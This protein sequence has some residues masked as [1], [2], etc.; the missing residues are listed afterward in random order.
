MSQSLAKA[1][2][3]ALHRGA[4]RTLEIGGDREL[5]VVAMSGGVDSSMAAA[6]LVEEGYQVTGVMM[7]LWAEGD[8]DGGCCSAEAAWGA[9]RVCEA[10]GIPF[11]V[12]NFESEFKRQVVDYLSAEYL[13]GNTPN[14]CIAC[15]RHIKFDLLL[16]KA[17]ALGARYL[18]TGHYARIK[19]EDSEYRLL[20]GVD[21]DKDQSYV[22]YMLGQE[23]LKQMLLPLGEYRKEWVRAEA[24][25]R[26]FPT[27][28]R[29]ESQDICFLQDN[30]YRR[31]L[32]GYS[33]YP[34]ETGPILD[35]EEKV[36]GQH[37]GL[38]FYT[39][40]Q[41]RGL[42]ISA[43]WPLYVVKIDVGR[44]ALVVG[45]KSALLRGALVAK[46]TS[47]VSGKPPK[48][49]LEG[50]AKIR[51]RATEVPA[52]LMPQG[53]DSF[54]VVFARPQPAITPGQAVV[55]YQGEVLIG[56]GTIVE[57]LN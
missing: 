47:F 10:L 17:L 25:A 43:P 27:A 40:G 24:W 26:G 55:L 14:P 35:M 46:E 16:R 7:R 54:K 22:L 18:A 6:L 41:R 48:G 44:N 42:R 33:P 12:L 37:Q 4:R 45:R 50:T 1:S 53:A 15:N 52:T 34:I 20:R 21:R 31:F 30:D 13:R 8:R 36:I 3:D 23:E 39:I 11:Y 49:S 57:S 19:R 32:A 28:E 9:Q 5:V 38:A 2:S 51:Y 56:G 29:E